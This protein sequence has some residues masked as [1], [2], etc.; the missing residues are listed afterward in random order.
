MKKITKRD[1]FFFFLG[2]LLM[3][4]VDIVMNWNNSDKAIKAGSD[5]FMNKVE[6]GQVK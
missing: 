6:K 1:I 4:I 5:A 2:I 3:L